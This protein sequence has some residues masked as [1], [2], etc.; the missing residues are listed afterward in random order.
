VGLGAF[1]ISLVG[2]ALAVVGCTIYPP[3]ST[4]PP[5]VGEP[6]PGSFHLTSDP[7]LA[8][9]AL[10][11]RI[12]EAGGPSRRTAEFAEGGEVVVDWST[13][14]L[15]PAKWIEVNG[16]DCVG[17][18]AIQARFETDLLLTLTDDVCRVEV[19]GTHLEGGPHHPRGG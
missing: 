16:Q 17:T 8:P 2:A 1:S 18:F 11:I 4:E 12:D 3:E 5:I 13:L 15:P 19:L 9:Y 7:P 10:T 6:D 14:P